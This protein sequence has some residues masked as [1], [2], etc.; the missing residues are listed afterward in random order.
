MKTIITGATG[1]LGGLI[2]R[3]LIYRKPP[4]EIIVSVRKPEAAE[5]WVRQG[6]QVRYGD[7]D[8][9]ESLLESFRGASKLLLI[10]SPY[11]DEN[12]RLKQHRAAIHAAQQA[13]IEHIV[14]TSIAYA[15][16][17]RLP[18]H[19]LH[20]QTEQA[21]R[22]LKIPY[23]FLRNAY[24]MDIVRFLGVREAVSSGILLS[25]PGDWTFNTASREDLALAA[26]SVLTEEGHMNRTYELTAPRAWKLEDL[27]RALTEVSGRNVLHRTDPAMASEIYRL[28]PFSEMKLTSPDLK[29][30]AGQP[31]HAVKDEVRKLLDSK[32]IV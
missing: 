15:E 24:Y 10:S 4:Q 20:L 8:A 14:Y 23:T 13:G 31:L 19:Q 18:L 29:R 27:A 7:Y 30:L 5:G 9:P 22:D 26:A 11:P 6:V 28:L 1:N 12:V 17:G 21:I 32:F 25:P 3:Q 2:L 16:K